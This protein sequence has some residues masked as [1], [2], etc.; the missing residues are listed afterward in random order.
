MLFSCRK[1]HEAFR[2][3][4]GVDCWRRGHRYPA[5]VNVYYFYRSQTPTFWDDSYYLSG[6]LQLYDALTGK[7]IPGFVSAFSHL[8]GIKA[9]L[10]SVLPV[11]IYL[12]FGRDCDPRF[13]VGIGFVI[14]MSIYLF[15]LGA[16]LWSP[17]E[18][19]LA[20]A[21]LQTMPL[22]YGLSRQFLVDYGL[23][24]IVVMWMYYLLCSRSITAVGTIVRLGILLGIGMLMKVSFPL[25]IGAP[26][27]VAIWALLRADRDWRKRRGF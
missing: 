8:Y 16:S 9:P 13:L 1:L 24:T 6:S 14:L 25:Y 22:L 3:A 5:A 7:G 18:G 15:R 11:P 19:L 10:I 17:R 26:T 4:P 23:A 27:I 2:L 21:I 20:V 12:I